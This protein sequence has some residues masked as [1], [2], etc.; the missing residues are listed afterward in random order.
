MSRT[1]E[2]LTQAAPLK[3]LFDISQLPLTK[4]AH[5]GFPQEY[6]TAPKDFRPASYADLPFP[7]LWGRT[8]NLKE[9]LLAS[10]TLD[11]S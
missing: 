8:N 2:V 11:D 9:L 10:F 7:R 3:I 5:I 4:G 1:A 6:T